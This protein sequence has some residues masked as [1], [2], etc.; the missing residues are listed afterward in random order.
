MSC[1]RKNTPTQIVSENCIKIHA[2][3]KINIYT[4]SL[5]TQEKFGYLKVRD[6]LTSVILKVFFIKSIKV[7]E[8]TLYCKGTGRQF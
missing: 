4:T 3:E 6:N 7:A 8:T 1:L 5:S 2:G